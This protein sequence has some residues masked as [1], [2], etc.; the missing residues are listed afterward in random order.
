MANF[1]LYEKPYVKLGTSSDICYCCHK[2]ICEN[3][4]RDAYDVAHEL[5]GRLDS[6]FVFFIRRS[7]QDT[8]ICFDCLKKIANELTANEEEVTTETATETTEEVIVA[9]EVTLKKEAKEDIK[10]TKKASSKKTSK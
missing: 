9:E 6:Q 7:G 8:C 10:E 1:G 4:R 5:K 2:E 3:E